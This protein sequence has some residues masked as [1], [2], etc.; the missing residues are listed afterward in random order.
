MT[1]NSGF[2]AFAMFHAFKLHFTGNYDYIKYKGKTNVSKTTFMSRKDKYQFYKLSRKY[3]LDDL[4]DFYISNFI[5][6]DIQWIGDISGPSGEENYKKWQKTQQS[7]TYVFE[8]DIIKLLDKYGI[9]GEMLFR[10]DGNH[11]PKLLEEVMRDEVKLET[12]IILNDNTNF[13]EKHWLPRIEDDIVWPQWYKK[14]IKY[15]PF[16][17]YDKQSFKNILKTKIQDYV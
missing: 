13:V 8:N 4:R 5:V 17:H 12:L 9:K 14:I 7:L 15:T 6:D 16:L 1:E 3:S 11:Y 10:V 2:A